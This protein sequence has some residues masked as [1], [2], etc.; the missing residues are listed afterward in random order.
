MFELFQS[1]STSKFH[2]RMKAGNGE[3]ILQSQAYKD[4]A[5]AQNGI[6]SVKKNAIG[7]ENFEIR[8]ASNG[9]GYF[10]LKAGNG[11][12]VGQSQQYK[13]ASGLKNGIQSIIKNASG[14]VKDLTA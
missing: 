3:V 7:E 5:S 4:K 14:D 10:V 9:K 11:Q 6:E 13:T 1:E 2:F 12:V 8:E